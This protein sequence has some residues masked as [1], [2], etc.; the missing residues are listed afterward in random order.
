M[1]KNKKS[2][3][4]H[5]SASSRDK[6]VL[7]ELMPMERQHFTQPLTYT[8]LVVLKPWGFEFLF[9]QNDFIAAWMLYIKKDHSTS[10][11]CHSNK[12]TSLALLSG[13]GLCS[14]FYSRTFL[15]SG[16]A[17]ILEKSVFHCTKALSDEGILIV[18]IETPPDK[19]DLF[20]LED[21]YGRRNFSYESFAQMERERLNRYNYF[22][23]GGSNINTLKG[24][25]KTISISLETLTGPVKD[26]CWDSNALYCIC[27]GDIIGR[28]GKTVFAIGE[29]FSG[30][31]IAAKKIL[32]V[33]DHVKFI[34]IGIGNEI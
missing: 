31:S 17:M 14:T 22:Q 21:K 32:H 28:N 11:H 3:I 33:K 19:D 10:M 4:K 9:Y 7:D 30:K 23:L 16:C 20:R 24:F 29:V 25:S 15:H 27:E 1:N 2:F 5:I 6:F 34:K 18:E 26:F 12:L 8:D 13:E